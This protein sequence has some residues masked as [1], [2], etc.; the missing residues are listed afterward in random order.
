[1]PVFLRLLSYLRPYRKRVLLGFLCLLLAIALE[2]TPGLVWK[3]VVDGLLPR[4][5]Y[6]GLVFAAGLLIAIQAADALMS[7][8]R[9][10]MLETVGQR[11][12]FD[13]RCQLYE[14]LMRLPLGYFSDARTGDLMSRAGSD[15]EAVQE[16]VIRGTDSVLAN[17]LRLT[18]VTI[19]FCSLNLKL[20]LATLAPIAIV[21]F[22]LR[23]FNRQI[24]GAYKGAREKLGM[25]T[26]K[27][28][29]DL[30]GIRVV[31]G[32]ARERDEATAFRG[33]AG[34][35]LEEN[36][37]AIRTRTSFF[38][39]VRW[40]ASFG[41]TIMIGYGGY[42]VMRG[43]FTIGGLVAY[44]AYGRYFFGPIDD[45]TQINDT[46]QRAI[47]AGTR[48]FEVLDTPEVIR[49]APGAKPLP[50]VVGAVAF[51][52]VTFRY[53]E[54]TAPVLD[55][56]SL[57]IEPGQTAALVGA[58]GAGKSTLFALLARFWDP[59]DGR[60]LIDGYDVR[61]VT[62][63]SLRQ[64]VVSV[65][66]ETFLFAATVAENIRYAR[67]GASDRDVE[68][69][70]R[71]ANAHGFISSLPEGYHTLIGER[72]V[73]LSG[74]QRQRL[75]VARAFLADSRVL[76]LDEATS[77]VEPESEQIIQEALERLMRGRTTI[78]AAHR[79]STI[80]NADVIFV[81]D[82]AGHIAEQGSH[83]KLMA[84]GGI[85]ARM[86]YQQT[87]QEPVFRVQHSVAEV[88]EV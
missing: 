26:T 39:F 73:K 53:K 23:R 13:L 14:K 52:N 57:R 40:I 34:K 56:L 41:N 45:L 29:E 4:L 9:S 46:V 77:S 33:V 59:E 86:V 74:G 58:S 3:H 27:L 2:L 22:L 5:D 82:G 50:P 42:L 83:E 72:G 21:G 64:Q 11:F 87:G 24:K 35:Y 10:R 78:I 7:A 25:V 17:F 48:I 20:G 28:Q 8:L 68:E 85:Y 49:D 31:K 60:V 79:L 38:P 70:A 84:E 66:Q 55:R 32:F 61:D 69:A 47:A 63:E 67:P 15:V 1:M 65:P 6:R 43:E 62:Q 30:S 44:R 88:S 71:A 75:A 54:G 19:I 37:T 16:V 76:L 18:G 12:V 81:L 80:R 51:E 36:L